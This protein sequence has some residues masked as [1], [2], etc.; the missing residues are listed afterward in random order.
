MEKCPCEDCLIIPI[1]RLKEYSRMM[2]CDIIYKYL[3]NK[4]PTEPAHQNRNN[5]FHKRI[6]TVKEIVN[7]YRWTVETNGGFVELRNR[8]L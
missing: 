3:Y 6:I 5:K 7:P 4:Y 2:K 8:N 1:C